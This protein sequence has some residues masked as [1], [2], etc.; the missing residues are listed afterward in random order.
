MNRLKIFA[1][2]AFLM[3]TLSFAWMGVASAHSFH[4][5][6]NVT[7]NQ[8]EQ[9]RHTVFASG[10]NINIDSEV[11]GDVFCAGQTVTVSGTVHGDVICAGQTVHINGIVTGDIRL[12]GQTVTVGATVSGNATIAGQSF[13]LESAGSIAGDV[14]V[15]S[16]DAS[17]NGSVGRDIAAGS[18]SLVISSTV[19]RDVGG[20]VDN[21]RL[22]SDARI[23]GNVNFISKNEAHKADGAVVAGKVTRNEPEKPSSS[24]RGTMFGFSL[25]WFLYWFVA[26]LLAAM[27][28]VLLFPRML[29]VVTDKAM[30]R[31]WKVLLIGLLANISLPFVV[32]FFAMT[33][34]GIPLA[35]LVGLL[36]LVVLLLSGPLF[37]Y[38]LGRL[39]MRNSRQPLLIMLIGASVLAA[40]YFIP[41]LGFIA[42]L[43]AM[44]V[45]AGMLL[46]EV[47]RRTP[48]PSYNVVRSTKEKSKA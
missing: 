6:Q 15:G 18:E 48:R 38:Y 25:G 37:G 12:A 30:P 46:L 19:G 35:L 20:S 10:R 31:P 29:Q 36:W 44:W 32:I 45:G 39:I 2:L 21:L 7:I 23:D 8:S 42:W 40:A 11:F 43:A 9:I 5:G 47:F 4:T 41:V 3:V 13:T 1:G 33:L 34:I 24:K 27:A 17:F 14:T 26:M 22:S 28:I 16:T